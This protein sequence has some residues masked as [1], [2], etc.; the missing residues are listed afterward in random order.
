MAP[1]LPCVPEVLALIV[2]ELTQGQ[3]HL[4]LPRYLLSPFGAAYSIESIA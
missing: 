1:R 4:T 3:R 2:L